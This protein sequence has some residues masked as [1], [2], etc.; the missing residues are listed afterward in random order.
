M[1]YGWHDDDL[2]LYETDEVLIYATPLFKDWC[3][4]NKYVEYEKTYNRD[5]VSWTPLNLDQL[6][7]ERDIVID[8]IE[9]HRHLFVKVEED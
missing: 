2:W 1:E 5:D 4:T 6:K 9:T 8:F 7:Q 3:D